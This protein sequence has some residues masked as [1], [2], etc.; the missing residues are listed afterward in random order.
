VTSRQAA[1][2]L[3]VALVTA[4]QDVGLNKEPDPPVPGLRADPASVALTGVCGGETTSVTLTNPG[5][6]PTTVTA[7]TISGAPWAVS[8]PALPFTLQPD[9]QVPLD[10]TV[11]QGVA[12]LQI[13]SDAPALSVPLR[14]SD[15]LHPTVIILSP[16]E[17]EVVAEDEDLVL[18]A[19]VADEDDALADLT[20]AWSSDVSG[21]I[22]AATPDADGRVETAWPAASR[23]AG[24]Q[25]V[26][27]AATD[28]CGDVGE[29][30]QYYCQDG[31]FAVDVLSDEAWRYDGAA[32]GSDDTLVLVSGAGAVGAGFDLFSL[33]DADDLQIAF[34]FRVSDGAEGLAF[35][36]LDPTR[37]SAYIGGA[38][39]GLGYGDDGDRGADDCTSGPALPGWAV[40]LDT[41]AGPDDCAA[42]DH[43]A[44]V[45]D[46]DVVRPEG[47]AATPLAGDWHAAEIVVL[48]GTIDVRVDGVLVLSA[49]VPSG[50]DFEG[51]AGFT[52][53]SS[54][55]GGTVEVTDVTVIDSTCVR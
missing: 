4:C 13:T 47:C 14:A 9:D 32:T 44:V 40:E 43:V 16:Y 37:L 34:R 26:A 12:S 39:C 54:A 45:L 27:L 8:G 6:G 50:Q 46:G 42:G 17:S 5:T 36:L 2:G 29:A 15:N 10:L 1:G 51:F 3:V 55:L 11:G 20:L 35:V 22:A 28:A 53:A 7:L 19:L 23:Q 24:P 49:V 21:F 38:G 18:T 30:T 25:T 41:F 33:F 31:P 52:A 48:S